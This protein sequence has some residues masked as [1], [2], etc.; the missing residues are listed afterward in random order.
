MSK[1]LL[2]ILIFIF[3]GIILNETS[4]WVYY[5]MPETAS[6]YPKNLY[7]DK[8]Y[9]QPE[10]SVAYFIY[11]LC[12]YISNI[13]NAVIFYAVVGLAA[14]IFQ[15]IIGIS[16][17]VNKYAIILA[18]T[19]FFLKLKKVSFWFVIYYVIEA[20]FYVWNRNTSGFNNLVV[21]A[22]ILVVLLQIILI[23]K[24]KTAEGE[25]FKTF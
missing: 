22:L 20:L 15:S 18:A 17:V 13:I 11:E 10:I 9:D 16:K 3:L 24:S 5:F 1:K 6:I 12:P 7:F 2:I 8:H 25:I 4:Y 14:N 19:D 21:I 23:D